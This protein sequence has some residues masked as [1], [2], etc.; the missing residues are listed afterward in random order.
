MN[1][2]LTR[3]R[4]RKREREASR[5]GLGALKVILAF[6]LL[7]ESCLYLLSLAQQP[8]FLNDFFSIFIKLFPNL[9][10]ISNSIS[11][12]FVFSFVRP[13]KM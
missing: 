1:T 2:C 8:S 6:V 11:I 3:I 13:F 9:N 10:S 12:K 7:E 4:M 5:K